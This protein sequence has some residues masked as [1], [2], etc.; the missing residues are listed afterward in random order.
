MR[1]SA[2]WR[3]AVQAFDR[4]YLSGFAAGAEREAVARIVAAHV[5]NN[6]VPSSEIKQLIET[7]QKTI[8]NLC[9]AKIT[10]DQPNPPV[11]IM[12]SIGSDYLICLEDGRKL[13]LLKRH[14]K[15][16]YGMSP[17]EYRQKWGLPPD[18]PMV[19]P[20]Y[21]QQRSVLA[22]SIGLGRRNARRAAIRIVKSRV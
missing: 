16:H 6:R 20:K 12:H 5:S 21:R 19:A 2:D 9:Q 7:V 10:Q 8:S 15:S 1:D 4:Q 11:L 13:K 3:K 22:Q 18:Y 14:L 17:N